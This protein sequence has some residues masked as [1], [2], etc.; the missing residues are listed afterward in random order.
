MPSSSSTRALD[1]RLRLLADRHPERDVV[2]HGHVL[3]RGVVLEHEADAAPLRRDVRD[4]L[5]GDHDRPRIG[6]LEPGDDAQQRRLARP[7]RSEQRGQRAVGYLELTS[8][9]AA[10]SPNRFDAPVTVI[11]RPPASVQERS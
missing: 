8:S 9:S 3:E 4:V 10:K 7:A 5:A 1:L 6:R 11:M 2:A